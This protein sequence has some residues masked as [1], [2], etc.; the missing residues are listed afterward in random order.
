MYPPN[1][2]AVVDFVIQ[3]KIFENH[4]RQQTLR[5]HYQDYQDI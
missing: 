5:G 4:A 3:K 2:V 1:F